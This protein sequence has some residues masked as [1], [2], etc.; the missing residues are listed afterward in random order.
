VD[1]CFFKALSLDETTGRPSVDADRC[2][3][4][5][6]CAV[7]C[8]QKTLKLVRFERS[9]HFESGGRLLKTIAS[10]NRGA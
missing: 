10:E 9:K 8:P 5:G 1:R 2:I 6:V 3:G 4:C 7:G